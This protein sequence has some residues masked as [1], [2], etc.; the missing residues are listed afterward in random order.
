MPCVLLSV[1]SSL[2][3]LRSS[4]HNICNSPFPCLMS[5]FF[6]FLEPQVL[7]CCNQTLCKKCID[8]CPYCPL[9]R[10][11]PKPYSPPSR[12]LCNMLARIEVS[13]NSCKSLVKRDLFPTHVRDVCPV[14][15]PNDC[16]KVL[17][18]STVVSH[19][20]TCEYLR[21]EASVVGCKF[22]GPRELTLQ[23]EMT[24]TL[25]SQKDILLRL[26][27]MEKQIKDL[28]LAVMRESDRARFHEGVLNDMLR[29]KV[30]FYCK[31]CQ[32]WLLPSEVNTICPVL[33]HT[34]YAINKYTFPACKICQGISATSNLCSLCG[35]TFC[36]NCFRWKHASKDPK[37]TFCAVEHE[38]VQSL[39]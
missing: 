10:H 5:N 32:H 26:D 16:S 3:K 11:N 17:T 12:L 38:F 23:H 25:L 2:L 1:C 28:K 31:K 39:S 18:R 30:I 20:A 15:C 35:M 33:E 34:F 36:D 21:C 7:R 22:T 14:K 8:D 9:C 19:L 6:R 29:K 24:C 4:C 27:A 37:F 13:C